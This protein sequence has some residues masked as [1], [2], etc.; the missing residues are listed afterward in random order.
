MKISEYLSKDMILTGIKTEN[1]YSLCKLIVDHLISKKII[2]EER[3]EILIDKII[4]R[5]SMSSTGIGGGVA[6]PHASGEDI[7]NIIIVVAQIPDGV[8]F[9]AIDDA[10]VDLVFMIIGSERVPRIHLQLLATIVRVC[11]N[12]ELVKALREASDVGEMYE[13]I[14]GFDR[15]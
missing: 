3:R 8:D 14:A 9:D 6:I 13:L 12:V 10:P 11:K 1:K 7:D 15:E 5:E 2:A 4:E